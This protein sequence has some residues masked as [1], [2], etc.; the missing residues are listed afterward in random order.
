MVG[1]DKCLIVFG[2]DDRVALVVEDDELDR[3]TKQ[4]ALSVDGIGPK[5]I[6]LSC[7]LAIGIEVA[8]N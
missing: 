7:R 3:A 1:A 6:A 4:S 8:G 5:L 2:S